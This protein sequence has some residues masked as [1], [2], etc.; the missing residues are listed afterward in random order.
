MLL[1]LQIALYLPNA[2]IVVCVRIGI[3]QINDDSVE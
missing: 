2:E 3:G 1:I